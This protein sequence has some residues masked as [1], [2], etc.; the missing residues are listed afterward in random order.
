MIASLGHDD[1]QYWLSDEGHRSNILA[2]VMPCDVDWNWTHLGYVDEPREVY[3]QKEYR[4]HQPYE[5]E[6]FVDIFDRWKLLNSGKE[7]RVIWEIKPVLNKLGETLRQCKSYKEILKADAVIVVYNVSKYSK[8][9]LKHFFETE[10]NFFIY[11]ILPS[12]C[13]RLE[14]L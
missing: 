4:H 12:Q 1:I 7:F 13:K 9:V 14:E 10:Q 2:E 6:I 3:S 8:E 5:K 11:Q